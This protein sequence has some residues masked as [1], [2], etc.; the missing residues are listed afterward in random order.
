VRAASLTDE[1]GLH[2]GEAPD[3]RPGANEVLVRVD[4]AGVCGT[5]LN[6]LAAGIPAGTVLGHEFTGTVIGL[7]ADVG[8]RIATGQRVVAV[9]CSSCGR[10]AECLGGDLIHCPSARL[11][12]NQPHAPGG[13]AEQV[14]VGVD[15]VVALPDS[16]PAHTAALVEPLAVGLHVV[17]RAGVSAR[18][19]VLV[20]GAGPI[21][22]TV[23]M[24]ARH[25]GARRVVVSDPVPSRRDMA[26]AC[27]ATEVLDPTGRSMGQAWRGLGT[28]A[29]PDVV[30][31]CTG[32][33]DVLQQCLGVLPRDGRLTVSGMHNR[34][35]P[36]DLSPAY[37]KE[38]T[39]AFSSWYRRDDFVYAVEMLAAGRLD[40]SGLRT[41]VVG[42]SALPAAFAAQKQPSAIGKLL[43]DPRA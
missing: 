28:G 12:G 22:L 29:R 10:C 30:I 39:V 11:V 33:G 21:G 5:D 37:F 31:E 23:A 16:V 20:V 26:L 32:R 1:G 4:L 9:P 17:Q 6:A 15:A 42:L 14:V 43:V 2:L 41:E 18:D 25:L 36:L 40:P 8:D 24:W 27:G 3:P 7:G 35:V 38:L 34:P 13:F 19:R